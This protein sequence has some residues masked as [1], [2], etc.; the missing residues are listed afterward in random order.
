MMIC[1]LA[2][3]TFAAGDANASGW[4]L[5]DQ[6]VT[7]L[8][9]A[10][11]DGALAGDDYSAIAYNPAAMQLGGTGVQLGGTLINLRSDVHGKTTQSATSAAQTGRPVGEA[12]RSGDANVNVSVVVPNFFA[13]YKVNEKMRVGF[14]IYVPFGLAIKYDSNWFAS[15][16]GIT[17]DLQVIDFAPAVSYE[18]MD[19]LS[20]GLAVNFRKTSVFLTSHNLNGSRNEFDLE[21]WG[22]GLNVGAMYK[23]DENTRFGVSFRSRSQHQ[24]KGDTKL[25]G[26][27]L[28]YNTTLPM[29]A[30][31][32]VLANV[33]HRIGD[34]GLSAGVEWTRWSRF[35]A[36]R[37]NNALIRSQV[38]QRW[39]NTW[40]GAVGLDYYHS[41]NWTFRGG[42]GFDES[43]VPNSEW[44]TAA[45]ADNDR[46]M[47]SAGTSYKTGAWTVDFGYSFLYL[48]SY[49]VH[50]TRQNLSG[51]PS[52]TQ[53]DAKYDTY[54]HVV[55][56]QVQYTF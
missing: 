46:W 3:L 5:S 11:S 27:D 4:G 15:E 41:E 44:R 39:K 51:T 50:N 53:L 56:L 49:E 26:R 47:F 34:F 30:P 16:H 6:S 1:S 29:D 48:P 36:L 21:D 23:L 9:R 12:I 40:R 38:G 17:S 42:I 43:P 2:G 22:V 55:G 52:T 14:G 7:G 33:Y 45:I 28:P 31:E 20:L 37:L 19:N 32:R 35:D 10:Y 25:L 13:Q 18:V 8:G 24:I 54:A